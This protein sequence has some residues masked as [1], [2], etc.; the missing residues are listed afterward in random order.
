MALTNITITYGVINTESEFVYL[1]AIYG[2]PGVP[3]PVAITRGGFPHFAR[4]LA[5]RS[6]LRSETAASSMDDA[7]AWLNRACMLSI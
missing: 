5:Q 4:F 7:F 3:A 1:E 2:E 6:S